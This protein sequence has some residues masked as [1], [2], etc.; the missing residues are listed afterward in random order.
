M[1]C[2][3][4]TGCLVPEIEP[5]PVPPTVRCAN[6][7]WREVRDEIQPVTPNPNRQWVSVQCEMCLVNKS[8]RGKSVCWVCWDN[9]RGRQGA[10]RH[11]AKIA[12]GH[13]VRRAKM[14][15]AG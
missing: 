7:G 5:W 3:R 1:R 14:E 13:A 6:C 9:E 4:C 15:E 11:A 10:A 8:M 12:A 2:P